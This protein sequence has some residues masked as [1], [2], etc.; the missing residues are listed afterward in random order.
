V[1]HYRDWGDPED[2]EGGEDEGAEVEGEGAA[3]GAREEL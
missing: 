3:D 1:G 2:A